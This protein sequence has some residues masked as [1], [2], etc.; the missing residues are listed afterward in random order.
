MIGIHTR[1]A[2]GRCALLAA[3][4]LVG[5]TAGCDGDSVDERLDTAIAREKLTGDPASDRLVVD[6]NEP[7]PQLGKLLF[8]SKALGGDRDAACVTCHHPMLGGGDGL[9]LSVGVGAEQA[10][11]LGPGRRHAAT[12]DH[13]DGGPTVPRNAPTTFNVILWDSAMFHDGRVESLGKTAG[14]NGADGMGIRTPDTPYGIADPGAWIDMP[15]A[16]ARFPVTSPEE[17]RGFAFMADDSNAALRDRLAQ[18]LGDYGAGAGEL[19][20]NTWLAQFQ[21]ALGSTADAETLITFDNVAAAIGAYEA[22]QLFV[23]APWNRYVRG[24]RTALTD[25][26]KRGALVFF[27]EPDSGGA[28]CVRCHAGDRFTDE[29]FHVLAVPQIG[30]GKGDGPTGDNDFGRFRETG[31]EADRFAFRTPSLLNVAVTGPFGHSGAYATLEAIV[32]HHLDAEGSAMT[33][34]YDQLDPGVQTANGP[35][36]T[37]AAVNQLAALRA[38]GDSRLPDVALSDRQVADLVA[39]LE[40]LTDPCVT[41]RACMAPWIPDDNDPDPDG[42]RLRAV[43]AGGTPF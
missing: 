4:A 22:S 37:S 43:D 24:D 32:R 34:D 1:T 41:D 2:L 20:T 17:M 39:F 31:H 3:L 26:A 18:R 12:A 40:A 36:N 29:G 25:A 38:A 16:Q 8:F 42:L 14:A 9:A 5:L 21:Q 13:H 28:G 23:D 7:L 27:N 6:I 33:Y 19:P 15:H 30:R 11:L 10:D 35:A